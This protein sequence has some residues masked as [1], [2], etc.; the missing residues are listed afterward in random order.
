MR[1]ISYRKDA[2]MD[3]QASGL[4]RKIMKRVRGHGRGDM[5]F[6]WK[7]FKDLGTRGSI[8]VAL[9]RLAKVGKLRR[10]GR[11]MYDLPPASC[12]A[13]RPRPVRMPFSTPSAAMMAW[14][15]SPT[16]LPQPTRLA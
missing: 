6:T 1:Y 11:G 13:D 4:S 7:D 8:D 5:V 10:V 15:L 16:T 12:C 14:T 3:H 2:T 9:H